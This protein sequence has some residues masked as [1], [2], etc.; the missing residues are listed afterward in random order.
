MN[1]PD[2]LKDMKKQAIGKEDIE[3]GRQP[4]YFQNNLIYEWEQA[5]EEVYVYIK[6]PDC[7]LPKNR[8]FIRKNLKPGEL[9][10]K[11]EVEFQPKH[12]KVGIKGNSPY[13]S[14]FS[15]VI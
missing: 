6:A 2:P 4:F 3:L 14:V 9:L 11:L 8:E 10:P 1:V 7:V 13:I 15:S 5:L 12:L